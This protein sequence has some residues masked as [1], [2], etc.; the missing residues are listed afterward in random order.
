MASLDQCLNSLEREFNEF[1]LAKAEESEK[2]K[3]A[4][5]EKEQKGPRIE[6]RED[7]TEGEDKTER[8]H[9]KT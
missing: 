9:S 2:I 1:L 5:A 4:E 3:I 6:G 8:G 7:K